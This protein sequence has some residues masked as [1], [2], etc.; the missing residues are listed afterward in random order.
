MDPI[1]SHPSMFLHFSGGWDCSDSDDS[2]SDSDAGP[3][4][5]PVKEVTVPG[6]Q[7]ALADAPTRFQPISSLEEQVLS[8]TKTQDN[9]FQSETNSTSIQ[10]PSKKAKVS[11]S[12]TAAVN[13]IQLDLGSYKSVKELEAEGLDRLKSALKAAGLKCGGSL[14]E[15]AERLFSVKGLSEAEYPAD[16]HAA[17][18]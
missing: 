11:H 3:A 1:C 4:V 15:R 6:I 16:V 12:S 7:A 13:A 8:A 2:R 10:Q 17:S 18:N 9:T 14:R 5:E